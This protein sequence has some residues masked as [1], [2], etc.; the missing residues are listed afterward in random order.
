MENYQL[1]IS[2]E[3]HL[4]SGTMNSYQIQ[5]FTDIN[6]GNIR[7][8]DVYGTQYLCY[9]DIRDSIGLPHDH[10]GRFIQQLDYQY[11]LVNEG[12]M[13]PQPYYYMYFNVPTESR[14]G[15]RNNNMLFITEGALYRL[16][17]RANS[18]KAYKFQHWVC[19]TVLPSLR[20]ISGG[21]QEL[22]NQILSKLEY[23]SSLTDES[24]RFNRS[25]ANE[26][27]ANSDMIAG[28]L[29]ELIEAND[30][31]TAEVAKMREEIN[32]I[33]FGNY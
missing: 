3:N 27:V 7:V 32:R 6:F 31:L 29:S 22:I 13:N 25:S 21:D 5:Q 16:V 19:D 20:R 23:L 17:L 33:K 14:M 9:N 2:F 11:K 12:S 28:R 10:S 15:V 1:P 30:I 18:D 4:Y 8:I 26:K 24:Y